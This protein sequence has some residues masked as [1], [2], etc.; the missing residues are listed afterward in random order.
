MFACALASLA[1]FGC[2]VSDDGARMDAGPRDAQV[3]DGPDAA[4]L[5]G[6]TRVDARDPSDAAPSPDAPIEPCSTRV[7]YGSSWIHGG[8][9]PLPYDDA[10]ERVT[11]DGVCTR[12][13]GN[14]FA[15]LSNG[16]RPIF[17]G[18][19]SCIVLLDVHG[20]CAEAPPSVCTTRVTYGPAWARAPGHAADYDEVAGVLT[21][22]GECHASGG[23]SFGVLSNGWSPHF[24]GPSA[25]A[26]SFRYE[27]CGG[28][29]ANPVV[30]TDCPDPGVVH[31]GTEYVMACTGGGFALRTSSD[32]VH[33][34]PRGEIFPTPP[35]WAS[36]SFWA[37]EIHHVGSQWVAYYSARIA[38]G[39]LALGAATA[40]S[41]LGPFTDL[42]APLLA[43]PAPG[44]IDAHEFD[45]PDGRHF[46]VWKVDGNAV[47]LATPIYIQQLGDDG[48]TLLGARTEI[49]RN[50][51][52][53]EGALVEG[54][55]MIHHDGFYYLFYS[56]NAYASAR[57]ALGV[58]RASSPLGPFEKAA[59]PILVSNGSFGGPG[60]GSVVLG[61][62]G[63]WVLVYHAWRADSIGT[64]PGRLV[65]VD[66]ISWRDG[67][68]HMDAAPSPRSQPLP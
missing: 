8:D 11:W 26:L 37:P 10:A 49:L 44:V 15:V 42:G 22:D 2:A 33:W 59:D 61:P 9:H 36:G 54:P 57:Y 31:D 43:V 46:L 6:E 21:W 29:F 18:S 12:D 3:A 48:V 52:A 7:T 58:A 38:G 65:L 27:Q 17:E 67:W 47:G 1:A 53:W 30:P 55:W 32:L 16:W 24:T 5:D 63:D 41:A 56:A 13:G 66:R 23:D 40:P 50:D 28:L 64:A 68:P 60:H 51:R 34:T 19:S 39:T 35:S 14:S 62:S 45:A 4:A 20:D 25:C